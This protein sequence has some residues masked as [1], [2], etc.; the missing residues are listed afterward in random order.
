MVRWQVNF[1][2]DVISPSS[3]SIYRMELRKCCNHP[4]LVKGAEDRILTDASTKAAEKAKEGGENLA[5]PNIHQI[6]ADQ[7]VKSSGKMVLMEK[8]LQKLFDGGHKVRSARLKWQLRF[9]MRV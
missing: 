9:P 7:L 8:L 3:C 4:F 2:H 6:F 1:S 5:M